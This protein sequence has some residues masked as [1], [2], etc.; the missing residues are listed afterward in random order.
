MLDTLGKKKDDEA[1]IETY[2]SACSD[3]QQWLDNVVKKL[4]TVD[5][6]HGLDVGLKL[7]TLYDIAEDL[8]KKRPEI[9]NTVKQLAEKVVNIVSNLDSQQVE[10]QVTKYLK[11]YYGKFSEQPLQNV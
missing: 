10:D 1:M 4:E 8:E 3:A 2:R 7:S 11:I 9:I 6:G 5:K